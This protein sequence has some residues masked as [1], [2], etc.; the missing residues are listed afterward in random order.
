MM[1]AL[2]DN[3][4][5]YQ[6][7]YR[8]TPALLLVIDDKGT[9]QDASE[10]MLE[11]TGWAREHLVGMPFPCSHQQSEWQAYPSHQYGLEAGQCLQ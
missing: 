7:F 2:R 9:V 4:E 11:V 5:R 10:Q 3:E 1:E 8:D 6:H